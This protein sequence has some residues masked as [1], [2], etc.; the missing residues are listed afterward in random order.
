[1]LSEVSPHE[2]TLRDNAQAF[3]AGGVQS[4]FDQNVPKMSTAERL[5]NLRVKEYHGIVRP[6]IGQERHLTA[7]H[8]LESVGGA[9]VV[10]GRCGDIV[11]RLFVHEI[12]KSGL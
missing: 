9:V 4:G 7:D 3:P 12:N 10:N 2:R 11:F 8:E 1:M 6:V 5:R